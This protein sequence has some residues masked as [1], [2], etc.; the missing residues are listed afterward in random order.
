MVFFNYL[1]SWILSKNVNN[2]EFGFTINKTE[3]WKQ[4]GDK[5][6]TTCKYV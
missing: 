3:N 1:H 2:Y 6:I 5:L 4:V